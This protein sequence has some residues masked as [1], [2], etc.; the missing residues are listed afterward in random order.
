M[1]VYKNRDPRN[2]HGVWDALNMI[3]EKMREIQLIIDEHFCELDDG[4]HWVRQPME[5]EE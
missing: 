2:T 1:S 4:M 3:L 5:E